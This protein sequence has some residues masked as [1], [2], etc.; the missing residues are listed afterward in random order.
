M[1][2][3]T[4]PLLTASLLAAIAASSVY[5]TPTLIGTD[6]FLIF[7]SPSSFQETP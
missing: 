2:L 6:S 5:V 4:N 1:R 3:N 7:L